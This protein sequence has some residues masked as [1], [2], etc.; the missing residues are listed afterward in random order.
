M[1][2]FLLSWNPEKFNWDTLRKEIARVRRKGFVT[3]R[4]SCGNR[5]DL[6]K[7]SEFFLIR[8]GP[9]LKGLVG[10]LCANVT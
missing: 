7:G 2:A 9:A 8:L 10:P 3:E 1:A 6:P 5:T 4:W